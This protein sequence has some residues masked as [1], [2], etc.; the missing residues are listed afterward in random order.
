MTLGFL[1][2]GTRQKIVFPALLTA[3]I[4]VLINGISSMAVAW[5]PAA[6]SE[7]VWR[8]RAIVQLFSAT[9]QVA[10]LLA[11]IVFVAMQG[12]YYSLVRGTAVFTMV[13]G[14]LLVA[15]LPFYGLD[16]IVARRLQPQGDIGAFTRE[17]L[18]MAAMSGAL[19]LVFVWFG[20]RGWLASR[21]DH[22][23]IKQTGHGLVVGQAD[24]PA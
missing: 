18:R 6:P 16:F 19:G 4:A 11:M 13:V 21:V 3:L 10:F 14:V 9:P 20:W 22:E 7:T 5:L 1:S 12:E 2:L 24:T 17:G 15:L 8:F 23:L